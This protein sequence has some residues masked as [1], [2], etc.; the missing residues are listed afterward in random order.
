[1]D[2]NIHDA[3]RLDQYPDVALEDIH[4]YTTWPYR[5]ICGADLEQKFRTR[6]KVL[7]EYNE[8]K[9]ASILGL[10]REEDSRKYSTVTE[11][12]D[13]TNKKIWSSL[14]LG[15]NTLISYDDTKIKDVL[16]MENRE[17]C[18]VEFKY[19]VLT[20][21]LAGHDSIVEIGSGYGKVLCYLLDRFPEITFAACGDLSKNGVE[22]TKILADRFHLNIKCF[23]HD[24]YEPNVGLM[25]CCRDA[26]V[27]TSQTLEQTP[28]TPCAL[29]EALIDA[30][31]AY[32]VHFEPI[33][34]QSAKRDDLLNNLR[35][36]YSEVCDY[37]KD[38]ERVL[39]NYVKED[40][41]DIVLNMRNIFGTNIFNPMSVIVWR[42]KRVI[43]KSSV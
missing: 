9:W 20:K 39:L 27:F 37:N 43:V 42:P 30:A 38:L 10:V 23:V 18:Q 2:L 17:R 31:P 8:T 29:I 5:L 3:L 13:A 32:V 28:E 4:D 7:S 15:M 16:S 1:M 40:R 21:F 34:E 25:A 33:Q 12:L 26:I 19:L 6:K 35:V 11:F 22:T 41:I 24:H 14:D 36:K